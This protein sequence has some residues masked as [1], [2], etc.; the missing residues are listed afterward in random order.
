M[1]GDNARVLKVHFT[2][3]KVQ[4]DV[5]AIL[6]DAQ[7]PKDSGF[8]RVRF[9]NVDEQYVKDMTEENMIK[10]LASE[11]KATDFT[12]FYSHKARNQRDDYSPGKTAT[13]MFLSGEGNGKFRFMIVEGKSRS[14]KTYGILKHLKQRSE[15]EVLRITIARASL[16]TLNASVLRDFEEIFE[17]KVPSGSREV[18]YGKSTFTFVGE[19][20]A[21]PRADIALINQPQELGI[22][23]ADSLM[24]ATKLVICDMS[25]SK[26]S[27]V[28]EH[29]LPRPDCAILHTDYR[30][31]PFLTE[32]A[33][34][35]LNWVKVNNPEM[36]KQLVCAE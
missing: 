7:H 2:K 35:D 21:I 15:Q 9:Y 36:Y 30:D 27:W 12:Q 8:H 1:A 31:N 28:E 34:A 6:F 18:A 24:R 32:R 20:S 22:E 13:E 33:L 17:I 5:E 23:F 25:E 3:D 11:M 4:Y 16:A 10:P 26:S 14:G 19:G 29:L